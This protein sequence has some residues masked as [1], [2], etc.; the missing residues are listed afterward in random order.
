MRAV[1]GLD[2]C[3]L[4]L[5]L[6]L[7]FIPLIGV[8]RCVAHAHAPREAGQRLA[9][10]HGSLAEAAGCTYSGEVGQWLA[11]GRGTLGSGGLPTLREGGGSD[12]HLLTGPSAVLARTASEV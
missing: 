8:C 4:F 11:P 10:G 7:A 5:Q 1:L 12:L 3:C 2:A 6:V 9:S